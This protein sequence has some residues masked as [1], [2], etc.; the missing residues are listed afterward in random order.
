MELI[1]MEEIYDPER[2]K[3]FYGVGAW[4]VSLNETDELNRVLCDSCE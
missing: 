3:V 1:F 2:Q 4:S